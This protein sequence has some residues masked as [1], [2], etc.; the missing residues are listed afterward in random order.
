MA[1][2]GLEA[3][4]PR[5]WQFLKG[6]RL[7]IK[8]LNSL[9]ANVSAAYVA[10]EAATR[11]SDDEQ[12]P[13][14]AGVPPAES[15]SNFSRS[16]ARVVLRTQLVCEWLRRNPQVWR[17]LIPQVTCPSGTFLTT[18][19]TRGTEETCQLC[20]AGRVSSGGRQQRCTVCE[21]G[22]AALQ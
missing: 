5:L 2:T 15:W 13:T 19:T 1:W 6:F 4:H 20:E 14:A 17:P 9:L 11:V 7:E 21:A 8:T 3:V 10:A 18:S 16:D 12:L 22:T